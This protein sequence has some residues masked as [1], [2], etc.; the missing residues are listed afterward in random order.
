[1]SLGRRDIIIEVPQAELAEID[2]WGHHSA[3]TVK[4]GERATVD[5]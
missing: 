3:A 1:V 4:T 2:A 5:S